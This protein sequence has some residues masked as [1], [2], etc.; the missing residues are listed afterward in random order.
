MKRSSSSASDTI[1]MSC[2]HL[3]PIQTIPMPLKATCEKPPYLLAHKPRV[4]R[5]QRGCGVAPLAGGHRKLK[6]RATKMQHQALEKLRCLI[7]SA[8]ADLRKEA[9]LSLPMGVRV[10]LLKHME[11]EKSMRS[12]PNEHQA[13]ASTLVAA[14]G[15]SKVRSQQGS[16]CAGMAYLRLA[17]SHA[18]GVSQK[19][20]GYLAQVRIAPYISACGG[21][22]ETRPDAERDLKVLVSARADILA[23]FA[24][25]AWDK[26]SSDTA[27][28]TVHLLPASCEAALVSDALRLA[29]QRQGVAL[30]ELRLS[31]S[32]IVSAH[33]LV[34]KYVSSGYST[35]LQDT[36][37][38]RN[39]L[40]NAR[41]KGWSYLR[42]AWVQMAA[43]PQKRRMNW[44]RGVKHISSAAAKSAADGALEAYQRRQRLAKA[45]REAEKGEKD[46]KRLQKKIE[47]LAA[48]VAKLL[49]KGTGT[50]PFP[51]RGVPQQNLI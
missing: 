31:F 35:S 3:E 6:S 27:S 46:W 24:A 8:P 47:A 48:S 28:E 10:A 29:C 43:T 13:K 40:I 42:T 19:R 51:P 25:I 49:E 23:R 36:M 2:G 34:G 50:L 16:H 30:D 39:D 15:A 4:E 44:G 22:H 14:A 32:A 17:Q 5:V 11:A 41:S 20:G 12:Q 7:A 18:C 38:Q 9:V 33:A 21:C 1:A 37:Q 45:R 26:K